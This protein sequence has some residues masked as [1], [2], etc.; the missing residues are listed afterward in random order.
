M[1]LD[2]ASWQLPVEL[3]RAAPELFDMMVHG[4]SISVF[5][6]CGDEDNGAR[7]STFLH[8]YRRGQNQHTEGSANLQTLKKAAADMKARAPPRRRR[9][10]GAAQ[11]LPVWSILHRRM[12]SARAR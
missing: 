1:L 12:A 4:S 10:A 2:V 8:D 9:I 7:T 6:V 5:G 3:G 11:H